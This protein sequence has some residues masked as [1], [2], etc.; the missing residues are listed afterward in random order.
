MLRP[1]SRA[2]GECPLR[3]PHPSTVPHLLQ[4]RR[5]AG[6]E[7]VQCRRR[8]ARC[9]TRLASRRELLPDVRRVGIWLCFLQKWSLTWTR[10]WRRCPFTWRT[11]PAPRR[12]GARASS[13]SCPRRR[14]GSWSTSPS[15]GRGAT[16]G[17]GPRRRRCVGGKPC[18]GRGNPAGE[19]GAESPARGGGGGGSPA[20]G[21]GS[22]EQ[23]LG[24]DIW[25]ESPHWRS[26][27]GK[28][29]AGCGLLGRPR[30]MQPRGRG[31]QAALCSFI[32]APPAVTHGPG[33]EH[34]LPASPS[35]PPPPQTPPP[36]PH[37]CCPSPT[38]AS[39]QSCSLFLY[40]NTHTHMHTHAHVCVHTRT[41]MDTHMHTP[42]LVSTLLSDLP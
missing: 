10:P 22:G 13:L 32:A 15:C 35:C 31:E 17:S 34:Q 40:P 14:A 25:V 33:P 1:V 21:P 4:G 8:A 30:K 9:R 23:S 12:S 28:G 29:R 36:R 38:W 20:G 24:M 7:E 41:Y 11:R 42:E 5:R 37:P 3:P 16:R 39:P 18:R 19:E 2:F 26:R 6:V 27:F